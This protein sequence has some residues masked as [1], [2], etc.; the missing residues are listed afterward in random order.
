MR[1]CLALLLA[2]VLWEAGEGSL[3]SSSALQTCT[4]NAPA[5]GA[6]VVLSC[7]HQV[8]VT[9]SV[10]TGQSLATQSL[11]FSQS[12]TSVNDAA[13]VAQ[14][15]AQPLVVTVTKSPVWAVYP[16]T[17]VQSVNAKPYEAVELTTVRPAPARAPPFS[18]PP[19]CQD[20][21]DGAYESNPTCGWF[22]DA[23]GNHIP[24]SQGFCCPCD[25]AST[26]QQT[27]L[28][29]PTDQSRGNVNCNFFSSSMFMNGIPASASCLRMSPNWFAGYGIGSASYEFTLSVTISQQAAAA[30][31]S[32]STNA[33]SNATTLLEV[34]TLSP[35]M[36]AALNAN[37]TVSAE[38]LGDLGGF[39]ETVV[40]SQS[41]LFIPIPNATQTD[42]GPHGLWP[43][44][45]LSAIS[46]D[47]SACNEPGTSFNAFYN[48]PNRCDQPAGT[49]LANQLQDIVD[50][51]AVR[52]TAG[53]MP[54]HN[55]ASLGV[56]TPQLHDA[57]A[58]AS[59]P[60]LKR[61]ALPSVSLRNSIV[62]VAVNADS[63]VF[64]TNNAAGYIAFAHL[65]DFNLKSVGSF[66]SLS[67]N[68]ELMATIVN[69]STI[70]ANYY[71]S[72]VNCSAGVALTPSPGALAVAAGGS[73]NQTWPCSVEDD[74]ALDRNCTI[75]LQ[76]ALFEIIDTKVV[77]FHTN[78]T[79]YDTHPTLTGGG[80][81]TGVGS[82]SGDATCAT[83]CPQ[84]LD[85]M[86]AAMNLCWMRLFEGLLVIAALCAFAYWIV[87][88]GPCRV[89]S[90]L[91]PER[92]RGGDER[93]RS[94][95]PR[96]RRNEDLAGDDVEEERAWRRGAAP[97]NEEESRAS[98]GGK[99][100]RRISELIE[101]LE[102]ELA[103]RMRRHR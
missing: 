29:G 78:A 101:Q 99:K 30:A 5:S 86:C 21:V 69:N 27:V 40:L 38:L 77:F 71:L 9:L 50:A 96:R 35:S 2:A 51:D 48:Q 13:G 1:L 28:G 74:L 8:V 49:C 102:A 14:P 18:S 88:G 92:R 57:Q 11:Q 55:L 68:G 39:Q 66:T 95:S 87:R 19:P 98:K 25:A 100:P 26:W 16:L 80:Q 75:E 52:T 17:Y 103:Q 4:N 65:V 93:G 34:L 85:L 6:T 62:V 3:V 7:R 41:M 36:L 31:G 32:G 82:R 23:S 64:V 59:Q 94:R 53:L 76:N 83:M 47:D 67:G 42:S 15:L 44:L 60:S 43:I 61:L 22:L 56:G 20:C 89:A 84:L 46:L 63:V 45:S 81:A 10:P 79:V 54:Q 70:P 37:E 97:A 12:L 91:Q 90:A 73:L 58:G 72:V 33:T 24:N